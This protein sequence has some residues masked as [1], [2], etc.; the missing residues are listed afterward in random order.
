MKLEN[1]RKE[2]AKLIRMRNKAR[3]KKI[4]DLGR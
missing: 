2:I 4:S 3:S 1:Q